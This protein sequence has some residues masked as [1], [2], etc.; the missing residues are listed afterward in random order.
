MGLIPPDEEI[1]KMYKNIFDDQEISDL[2][3]W[4]EKNTASPTDEEQYL[5]NALKNAEIIKEKFYNV[6]DEIKE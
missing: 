6:F 3:N 5:E 2:S 1:Y 4:R